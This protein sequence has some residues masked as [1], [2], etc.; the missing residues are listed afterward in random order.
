MP[1]YVASTH[2]V[3]P[4]DLIDFM[5]FRCG[6]DNLATIATGRRHNCP[7]EQRICQKCTANEVEDEY[8]FIS[9]GALHM[10][11]FEYLCMPS[12]SCLTV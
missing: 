8:D 9:S 2:L 11:L 6:S 10:N 1:E 12:I 4:C 5:R 7:R 3:F